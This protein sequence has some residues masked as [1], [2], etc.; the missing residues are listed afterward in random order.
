MVMGNI[1]EQALLLHPDILEILKYTSVAN[2]NNVRSALAPL[3][4]LSNI[5]VGNAVYSNTN[6]SATFSATNIID[7]D[8]LICYVTD[9]PGIFEASAG[10]TFAWAPG[11]GMGTVMTQRDELNDTDVVKTKEQWDQKAVAADCGYFFSDVV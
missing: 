9:A 6:E 5:Y 10:Y 7:D 2:I 11:G 4:G 1:V 3:L 8:C